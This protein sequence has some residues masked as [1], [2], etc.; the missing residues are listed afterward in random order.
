MIKPNN[1][2]A[3]KTSQYPLDPLPKYV[4]EMVVNSFGCGKSSFQFGGG[5]ADAEQFCAQFSMLGAQEGN[6]D[7]N[8]GH[9]C[10]FYANS[11]EVNDS[12]KKKTAC[13]ICYY[14]YSNSHPKFPVARLRAGRT[15]F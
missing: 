5:E 1:D 11:L 6:F 8:N 3:H 12:L 7:L 2:K 14:V 13:Q 4:L 15:K 9:E 10:Q